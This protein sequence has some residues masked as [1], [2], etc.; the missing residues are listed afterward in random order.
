M[1]PLSLFLFF[2]SFF[3]PKALRLDPDNKACRDNLRQLKKI[4]NLKKEGNGYFSSRQW[5]KAEETYSEALFLG[6]CDPQMNKALYSNR[7]AARFFPIYSF[8]YFLNLSLTSY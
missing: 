4:E 1:T 5:A 8:N 6:S 7:A 3:F 2:S